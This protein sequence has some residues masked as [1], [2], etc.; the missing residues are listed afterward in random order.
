MTLHIY[1]KTADIRYVVV[2]K[3]QIACSQWLRWHTYICLI[4]LYDIAFK[5][6]NFN[7]CIHF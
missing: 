5:R 7:I 4:N 3:Q 6:Q 1:Q 2:I